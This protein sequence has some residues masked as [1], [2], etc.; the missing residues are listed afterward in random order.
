MEK[1]RFGSQIRSLLIFGQPSEQGKKSGCWRAGLLQV[2]I[3]VHSRGGLKIKQQRPGERKVGC[4]LWFLSTGREAQAPLAAGT[5]ALGQRG[6]GRSSGPG[7][8]AGR[9]SGERLFLSLL[10]VPWVR[11]CCVDHGGSMHRIRG[12][13]MC[14]FVLMCICQG[15]LLPHGRVVTGLWMCPGC[16]VAKCGRPHSHTLYGRRLAVLCPPALGQAGSDQL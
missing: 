6:W 2:R 10:G 9:V 1:K 3:F 12:V 5:F 4:R 16:C 15:T 13:D 7:H 14:D 11:D 8:C